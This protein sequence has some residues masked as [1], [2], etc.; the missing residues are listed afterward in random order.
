[1]ADVALT[2][3]ETFWRGRKVFLTGHTGF[4]GG[5]LS[6]LLQRMGAQVTGYALE[7]S[8][9]PNLYSAARIADS[10]RSIFGDIRDAAQL[11]SALRRSEADIVFHLAAQALVGTARAEPADTFATNVMGTVNLL[12]AVRRV[13]SVES[14]IVV[15]SDKVYDNVEWPWAYRENDRLGGCEPYGASKACAEIA[16]DSYRHAYFQGT[17]TRIATVRAGNIIGGG[18][19]SADRLIPDAIRAFASGE[20]LMIRNPKAVRPWQHVLEPVA[21]YC[22]Y[23]E[24]LSGAKDNLPTSLNFGPANEDAQPVSVIADRLAELWR[25]A[26]RWEQAP[27]AQPYEARLLRVDSALAG[28]TLGWQPR[29]RLDAAL[30]H[31]VAWYKDFLGGVDARLASDRQIE[32]YLDA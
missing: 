30:I 29:W 10:G 12:E 15:T 1:M 18:D 32:R 17:D 25:G 19:W 24:A 7:P 4:K 31:T 16:V 2:P 3:S 23:A 5:W 13:A 27:G 6:L 28:T 20:P 9:T 8:T 11:E 21:G 14:V 22:R 26:A